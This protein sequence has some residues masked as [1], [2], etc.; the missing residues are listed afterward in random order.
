MVYLEDLL[1]LEV[2]LGNKRSGAHEGSVVIVGRRTD[3]LNRKIIQ[4]RFG[5]SGL[6]GCPGMA[7]VRETPSPVLHRE[8][9]G[10]ELL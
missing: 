4:A 5:A 7:N 6:L 2:L 3:V 8:C 9:H 10:C 1:T